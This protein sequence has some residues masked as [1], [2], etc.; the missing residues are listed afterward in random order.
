MPLN[1]TDSLI[2][3]SKETR[4]ETPSS[5]R[6]ELMTRRAV[7][8]NTREHIT[9]QHNAL[10][11]TRTHMS[12][13]ALLASAVDPHGK[14]RHHH[15]YPVPQGEACCC[16]LYPH[17]PLSQ[18]LSDVSELQKVDLSQ[19]KT[20]RP[21]HPLFFPVPRSRIISQVQYAAPTGMCA[22]RTVLLSL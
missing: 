17:L 1:K 4:Q 9:P 6:L 11:H 13:L 21:S 22:I 2:A 8:H 12:S 18:F 16:S 14:Q 10:Y 20:R 15:R 5:R 7:H 19:G 3:Q